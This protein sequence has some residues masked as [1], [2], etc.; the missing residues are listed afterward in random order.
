LLENIGKHSDNP[1]IRFILNELN[2]NALDWLKSLPKTHILDNEIFM[3]H[4]TPESDCTYLLE[5]LSNSTTAVNN[6]N[7]IEDCLK[8]VYQKIVFCGHSHTPRFVQTP[9]KKIINPGSIGLSAYDDDLPLYH[10]IQNFNNHAHYSFIEI[11]EG[12]INL[13]QISLPY[14]YQK[15]V[16]CAT[17]NNRLDWAGWIKTGR[18]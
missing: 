13:E 9:V 16:N 10:K 4:G 7:K 11:I 17:K 6:I 18:A 8:S 2:N 3:C 12:N 14:D 1:T 5:D 15:A